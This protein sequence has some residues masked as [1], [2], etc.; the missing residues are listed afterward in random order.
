M[1]RSYCTFCMSASAACWPDLHLQQDGTQS[2]PTELL[3][4]QSNQTIRSRTQ[5]YRS[6]PSCEQSPAIK[7]TID[8]QV[9]SRREV[10]ELK[11]RPNFKYINAPILT[12]MTC[13]P[14]D[15]VYQS[16]ISP[17]RCMSG[18]FS[19]LAVSLDNATGKQQLL[20][21]ISDDVTLCCWA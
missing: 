21:C 4:V 14:I 7:T 3:A 2:A 10:I 16:A 12:F 19:N 13:L 1:M 5:D 8:L 18:F 20:S 15:E 6:H 17:L 9:D 11:L